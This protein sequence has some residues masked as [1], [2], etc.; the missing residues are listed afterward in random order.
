MITGRVV[1]EFQ[2]AWTNLLQLPAHLNNWK[3]CVNLLYLPT[4]CSCVYPENPKG[5]M[6]GLP[7]KEDP[8][9]LRSSMGRA[10]QRWGREGGGVRGWDRLELQQMLLCLMRVA[11]AEPK[12]SSRISCSKEQGTRVSQ[13]DM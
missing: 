2:G 11:S 9:L 10:S 13:Q 1:R 12:I 4:Q 8:E 5:T 3:E 7:Y 6:T